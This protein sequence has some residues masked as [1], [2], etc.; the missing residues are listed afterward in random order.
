MWVQNLGQLL[1]RRGVT[2]KDLFKGNQVFSVLFILLYISVLMLALNLPQMPAF[3][4]E[5]RFYGMGVSWT[6]LRVMLMGVCGIGLTI[7]LHTAK[8]DAIA[9]ILIGLIVFGGLSSAEAYF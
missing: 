9:V 3:P 6:L 7:A 4:V 5:W 2:A 1:V 8:K